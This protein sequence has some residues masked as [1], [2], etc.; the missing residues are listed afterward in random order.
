MRTATAPTHEFSELR[1]FNAAVRRV[2]DLEAELQEAD[3]L[4]RIFRS[5]HMALV[6]G[7]LCY[8]C[9]EITGREQLDR[10]WRELFVNRD[11]ILQKWNAALAEYAAL[12]T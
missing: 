4:M 6:G 12:K 9:S 5:E 8:L 7:Q 3:R 11:K 1:L 2:R 10:R